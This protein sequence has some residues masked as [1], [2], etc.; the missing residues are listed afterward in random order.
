MIINTKP[1]T[2]FLA[3]FFCFIWIMWGIIGIVVFIPTGQWMPW[4]LGLILQVVIGFGL[5]IYT[6]H[7]EATIGC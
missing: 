5:I 6:D 7:M 1:L 4:V 2:T 3:I